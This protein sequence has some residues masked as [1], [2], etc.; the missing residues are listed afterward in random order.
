MILLYLLLAAYIIAINFY[1]FLLV[2][3][4]R[5]K[6]K[7]AEAARQA[8]PLSASSANAEDPIKPLQERYFGKLLI[9]GALGGA[10]T[11]YTCM[12]IFKYKRSD[13]LL[14]VLMPLLGVLNI[15]FFVLFFKSGFGFLLIR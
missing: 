11:I 2:K 5:D 13:L 15:Y 14:M 3:G 12:F 8:Q 4:L 1:A 7:Q 10:I 6:E 9:A